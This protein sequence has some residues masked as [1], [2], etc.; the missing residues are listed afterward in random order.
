MEV[1]AH[2]TLVFWYDISRCRWVF[3]GPFFRWC[4]F[5]PSR[6][7]DSPALAWES[8]TDHK[9]AW[10][11]P[12][13][14]CRH[15]WWACKWRNRLESAWTE[16]FQRTEWSVDRGGRDRSGRTAISPS[17]YLLSPFSSRR[18]ASVWYKRSRRSTWRLRWRKR[19]ICRTWHCLTSPPGPSR[20]PSWLDPSPRGCVGCIR[21]CVRCGRWGCIALSRPSGRNW[22]DQSFWSWCRDRC[23]REWYRECTGRAGNISGSSWSPTRSRSWS[24]PSWSRKVPE[25]T[26]RSVSGTSGSAGCYSSNRLSRIR[27]TLNDRTW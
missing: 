11:I 9:R 20:D 10:R 23:P 16:R 1:N 2:V 18:A 13:R 25:A 8:G 12:R 19:A 17:R 15:R 22:L 24:S 6:P 26:R 27:E 21:W 7:Q 14:D 4:S 3:P 5:F